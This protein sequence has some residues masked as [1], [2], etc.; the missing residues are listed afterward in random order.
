VHRAES[1]VHG[2]LYPEGERTEP[3]GADDPETRRLATEP[4]ERTGPIEADDPDRPGLANEPPDRPARHDPPG[5]D[6]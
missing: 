2:E 3:I 4:R 5:A 1:G 6:A